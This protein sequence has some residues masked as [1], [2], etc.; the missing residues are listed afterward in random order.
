MLFFFGGFMYMLGLTCITFCDLQLKGLKE[1][2][3]LQNFDES[4][5]GIGVHDL[6]REFAAEEANT[7]GKLQGSSVWFY[8]ND[9][10]GAQHRGVVVGRISTEHP[11]GEEVN[12]KTN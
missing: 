11:F 1:K 6:W 5:T 3:L 9:E 4:S 10:D 2:S 8:D 12:S 7:V